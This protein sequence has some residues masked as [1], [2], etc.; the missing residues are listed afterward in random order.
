MK[1]FKYIGSKIRLLDYL[2]PPPKGTRRIVELFAGSM[3]YG[4][5]YCDL[6]KVI[7]IE[8]NDRIYNIYEWLL[9]K[10]DLDKTLDKFNKYNR[11]HLNYSQNMNGNM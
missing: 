9:N 6:Y 11:Q 5:K 3:C 8:L 7:G 10:P 4:I 1:I 2:S